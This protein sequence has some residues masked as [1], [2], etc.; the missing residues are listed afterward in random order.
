MAD[1]SGSE[2]PT[3]PEAPSAEIDL[4]ATLAALLAH[5][6]APLAAGKTKQPPNSNGGKKGQHNPKPH[7]DYMCQTCGKQGDHFHSACPKKIT[8]GPDGK[9]MRGGKPFDPLN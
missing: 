2:N 4:A 1:G 5:V 3:P 9:P 7:S 6:K 8:K